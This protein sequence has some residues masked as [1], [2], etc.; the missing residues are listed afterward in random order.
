MKIYGEDYW[1]FMMKI[2]EDDWSSNYWRSMIQFIGDEW[3]RLSVRFIENEWWMMNDEWMRDEWWMLKDQELLRDKKWMNVYAF[4]SLT[5]FLLLMLL[6]LF[7][8]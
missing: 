2:V 1:R 3:F 6:T 8:Y 7:Y 5:L 4:W